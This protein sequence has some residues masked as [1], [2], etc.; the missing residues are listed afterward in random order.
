MG[1]KL[2]LKHRK[3][4]DEDSATVV[5]LKEKQTTLI[6][7]PKENSTALIVTPKL[8]PPEELV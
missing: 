6:V 3:D 2:L 4:E 7:A 8:P 1:K 5:E